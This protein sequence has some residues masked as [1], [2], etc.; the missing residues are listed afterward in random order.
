MLR[1][2]TAVE[3]GGLQVAA[4]DLV[5]LALIRPLA[6]TV[7]DLARR[8]AGVDAGRR[9]GVALAERRVGAEGI[10]SFGGGVTAIA[11][12][13]G[14][15]SPVRARARHAAAASSPTRSRPELDLP[16][17]TAEALKRQLG[18]DRATTSSSPAPAARSSGP[19]SV[20]LDEVR[21]SIDY[22]RN[23]PGSSPLLPHRRHRWRRAAPGLE[24]APVGARRRAGRAR[25]VRASSSRSATSASPTT[26]CRGSSRIFPP[27]S[28]SRSAAPASA[29]SS[30]CCR[31]TRASA[32]RS[33]GRTQIAPG[34]VAA[35][36]AFVVLLGG[37]TFLAHQSVSK[38]EVAA[39]GRDGAGRRRLR[40]SSPR[41]SRSS[42]A[43]TRSTRS[44]SNM[45]TLLADRRRV[46]DDDQPH[47]RDSCPPGITLTSF[48]G[49][50]DAAGARVAVAP[51][52]GRRRPTPAGS[53]HGHDVPPTTVPL[54]RRRR[55]SP[56]RSRSRAR[57]R[58]YPTLASVDRRDGQGARD[59][60]RLR[61]ECAGGRRRPVATAA[62][63]PSPRPR[64]RRR[65]RKS[66]RLTKY[67]KAASNEDQEHR[68]R[69]S[70][71]QCS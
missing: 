66:D 54:R 22:Y 63:S 34:A 27:R 70:R 7:P 26:S 20:L 33:R 40:R 56:A 19:L 17:E 55:R 2:V 1:L 41:C 44:R 53:E 15:R 52:A 47:H 9:G 51:A 23:Q 49:S 18:G 68:R 16:P 14:R 28:G 65:P 71:S 57:R 64:C 37:V 50:V 43:R 59:R 11:V 8:R 61:D 45:Q 62:D 38:R 32:R 13:E 35:A 36:A 60:R 6:R 31:G 10:V 3:A 48:T 69:R 25:L 12:H 21:S 30:T 39:R 29:R 58:D 67:V 46:A 5:P 42:T 4:V 24:R